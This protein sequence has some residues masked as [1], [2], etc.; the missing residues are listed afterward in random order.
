[1]SA[2]MGKYTG[3]KVYKTTLPEY[4]DEKLYR[5]K[6]NM[7][8]IDGEIIYKNEIFAKWDGKYVKELDP[9]ERAVYF[10][11]PAVKKE[12][13]EKL[14]KR[15]ENIGVEEVIT[16]VYET[17]YFSGMTDIDAFLKSEV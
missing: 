9:Q 6:E 11:V 7:Y 16:G 10:T 12:E 13:I 2:I 4:I 15:I 17:D 3:I 8:M 14:K 5:D 1:M